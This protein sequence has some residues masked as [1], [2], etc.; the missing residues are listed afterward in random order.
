MVY[1]V[2]VLSYTHPYINTDTPATPLLPLVL[3]NNRVS[4]Y[5]ISYL[6]YHILVSNCLKVS[7]RSYLLKWT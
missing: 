1:F 2:G 7:Q 6:S 3:R 5:L 4:L